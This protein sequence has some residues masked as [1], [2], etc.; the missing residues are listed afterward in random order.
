M[1]GQTSDYGSDVST[2]ER[3][4]QRI[5]VIPKH[6]DG[7]GVQLGVNTPSNTLSGRLNPF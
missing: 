4:G 6:G 3:L 5:V 7:A 2:F 1:L